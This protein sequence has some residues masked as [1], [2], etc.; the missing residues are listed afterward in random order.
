MVSLRHSAHKNIELQ[1]HSN[2]IIFVTAWEK[3]HGMASSVASRPTH[4]PWP[5][6]SRAFVRLL[7]PIGHDDPWDPQ[8]WKCQEIDLVD[9]VDEAKQKQSGEEAGE[10]L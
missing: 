7:V 8:E 3:V 10:D 9:V 4:A 6:A 2:L 1:N 5:G